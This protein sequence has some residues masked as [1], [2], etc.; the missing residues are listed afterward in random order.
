MNSFEASTP[1]HIPGGLSEPVFLE[2]WH[3]EVFALAVAL[4]RKGVFT[5]GEWVEVFSSVLREIPADDGESAEATYY[6]RWLA[7]IERLVAHYGLASREEMTER[8]EAWRRAYLRTPHG[9][10]VA[11]EE[12]APTVEVQHQEARHLHSDTPHRHATR[13]APVAVSAARARKG[14]PANSTPAV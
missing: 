1:P 4:N 6:R 11:L 8:K 3:A 10:P 14:N 12:G 5:W 9:Y 2:P 7:A 13:P